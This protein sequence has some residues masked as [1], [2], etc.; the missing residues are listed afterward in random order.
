VLAEIGTNDLFLPVPVDISDVLRLCTKRPPVVQAAC[1]FVSKF[2]FA[3]QLNDQSAFS[4][5]R[6]GFPQAL[7]AETAVKYGLLV[8]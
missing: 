4:H 7:L 8:A 5:V 1:L 3:S 6:D 2:L